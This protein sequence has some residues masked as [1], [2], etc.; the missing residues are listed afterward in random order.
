MLAESLGGRDQRVDGHRCP[1]DLDC[2][3][4]VRHR[5]SPPNNTTSYFVMGQAGAQGSSIRQLA[6][7]VPKHRQLIREGVVARRRLHSSERIFA[8]VYPY[9]PLR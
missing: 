5:K 7:R 6:A 3:L 4:N 1:F 2:V 8:L 9:P